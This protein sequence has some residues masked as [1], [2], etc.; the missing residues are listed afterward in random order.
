MAVVNGLYCVFY[1]M[2]ITWTLYYIGNSFINPLPWSHCNSWWNDGRCI[3]GNALPALNAS[4]I[5]MTSGTSSAE[6]FWQYLSIIVAYM[7]HLQ[8]RTRIMVYFY[9]GNTYNDVIGLRFLTGPAV[10]RKSIF[11]NR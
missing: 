11:Y 4:D 2:V 6:E 3:S 10:F 7:N 9:K 5:N 8:F 1:V